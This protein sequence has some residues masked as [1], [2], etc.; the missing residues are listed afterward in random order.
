MKKRAAGIKKMQ[1]SVVFIKKHLKIIIWK[2]KNCKV[3][4]HFQ[5]TGEHRGTVHS[6]CNTNYRVPKKIPI[7]FCKRSNYDYHFLKELSEEFKKQFGCFRE[8]TKKY[9]DVTIPI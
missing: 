4:D 5:Y 1:K 7:A 2:I 6:I 8:N 9:I 3:R